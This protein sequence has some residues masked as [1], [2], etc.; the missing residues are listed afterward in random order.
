MK[1]RADVVIVGSGP[2]GAV[3]AR[4]LS[5][6]ANLRVIL[7]DAGPYAK[8]PFYQPDELEMSKLYWD[9]ATR[10]TD[11]RSTQI[12]QAR[13]VGGG[14]IVYSGTAHRA[15]SFVFDDWRERWKVRGFSAAEMDLGYRDI[16]ARMH[17]T[18]HTP[19]DYNDNSRLFVEACGKLGL[20]AAPLSRFVRNCVGCGYCYQGCRPRRKVTLINTIIPE[21]LHNGVQLISNCM[22]DEVL[23][24]AG[25]R[26]ISGVRGTVG[27]TPA[28][29]EPNSVAPGPIQIDA[30]LVVLAGSAVNTPALLLRSRI[31]SLGPALGRF[32]LMQNAHTV[33]IHMHREVQMIRGVPKSASLKHYLEEKRF[34]ITPSQIHPISTA[35]DITGFGLK[36]KNLMRRFDHFLQWQVICG[37]D[38]SFNNH[39]YLDERGRPQVRYLYDKRYIDRQVEGLRTCARLGFAIGAERVFIGP[40]KKG[41]IRDR[42]AHKI[43]REIHRRYFSPGRF[44]MNT[45]HPQGGC[46]MGGN[47]KHSVVDGAGRA[48]RVEGLVVCDASIFP[49][50]THVNPVY[51]ILAA[52]T[53]IARRTRADLGSLLGAD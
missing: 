36:W 19:E 35:N 4:T 52:A 31:P 2:G 53:L 43:D 50:A 47:P 15:P 5:E 29:A 18:E 42:Y 44:S 13:C 48:H 20:P 33:N 23:Y 28:G 40:T 14:S 46:R 6:V 16:A 11:D 26:R 7:V 30:R 49:S 32:V 9:R 37:D 8:K 10:S 45:A 22:I 17:I 39:V 24:D 25:K 1:L 38:P 51:T 12:V 34:V 27:A 21:A 3:M 41:Y